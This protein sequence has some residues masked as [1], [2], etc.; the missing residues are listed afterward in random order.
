MPTVAI[1]APPVAAFARDEDYARLNALL[2]RNTSLVNFLDGCAVT[3]P[4]HAPGAA[5]VGLMLVGRAGEDRRLL[6]MAL[7]IEAA[8]AAA[9]PG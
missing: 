1:V 6:A 7:G 2:L 9:R 8:L 4:I 5:P 3:L